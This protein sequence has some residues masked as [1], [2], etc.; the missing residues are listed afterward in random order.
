MTCDQR[1]KGKITGVYERTSFVSADGRVIAVLRYVDTEFI[2]PDESL[3]P[4]ISVLG[5]GLP[6]RANNVLYELEGSWVSPSRYGWQFEFT[7][8]REVVEKTEAGITTYLSRCLKGIGE[9]TAK[10]IYA[11]F[12]LQT[13]DVLDNEPGKLIEIKGIGP[14]KLP[15]ILESIA[16]SRGARDLIAL[17]S[18]EPYKVSQKKCVE[19]YKQYKENAMDTVLKHP[20]QLIA[21]KGIG[22]KLCDK[23]A[24]ANGLD[25]TSDERIKAGLLQVLEEAENGG[26]SL[27]GFGNSGHL[28]IDA[29]TEWL[30]LTATLLDTPEITMEKIR[31]NAKEL[32]KMRKVKISHAAS[33]CVYKYSTAVTEHQTAVDIVRLFTAECSYNVA[34]IDRRIRSAELI[35]RIKLA[36]EQFEAVKMCLTNPF[37][38]ITGSP[39][40]G[41]TTILKIALDVFQNANP[42]AAIQLAAPTGKAARR[43]RETTGYPASTI[44]SLLGLKGDEASS[45]AMTVDADFLVVDEASMVDIFL[46]EKLF[47]A[48]KSGTRVLLVGD[49]NQLPSVRPGAVLSEVIASKCIPTTELKRVFR[50]SNASN[51]CINA[52]AMT[53]GVCRMEYGDDF[54]FVPADSEEAAAN[55]VMQQ[56]MKEVKENGVENVIILSPFRESRETSADKLALAAREVLN[57]Y[58]S[59]KSEIKNNGRIFRQG[60]R[61]MQIKNT[62]TVV[63]GDVGEITFLAHQA[64]MNV[65]HIMFETGDGVLDVPYED[66]D[67]DFLKLAYACTIHKSQGSEYATVIMVLLPSHR[68]MLQRNLVYTG[69][70]RA[71]KKLILVGSEKALAEAIRNNKALARKTLLAYRIS[72]LLL[73][74]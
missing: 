3:H 32:Q 74:E 72:R 29:E 4:M 8:F 48:I 12:G 70:T 65:G 41:K 38:V 2:A 27:F 55:V 57:P 44:H 42:K 26:S 17:L 60:D 54:I 46:A 39:G 6:E 45:E 40:T 31:K 66:D 68:I 50:Q 37:S 30:P 11:R 56:Y 58:S 9:K 25:K 36:E 19:I 16:A 24:M 22:F 10:D 23:I 20:Y 71:K 67:F 59:K 43:M 1:W 35:G 62:E 53:N 5:Y 14:K 34:D 13:L 63:N 21:I 69:I 47:S 61:V 28:Y 33:T 18:P 64:N 73:D 49:V 51:I 15:R 52:N 7:S